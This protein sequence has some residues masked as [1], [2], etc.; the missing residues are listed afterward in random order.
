MFFIGGL[1]VTRSVEKKGIYLFIKD[2]FLRLFLPFI[3]GGTLFMLLAYFPAFYLAHHS[4]D[5]LF[6]IKDFFTTESWPVGPPWFIWV[7]F[8]FNMLFVIIY[9][10]VKKTVRVKPLKIVDLQNNPA[11]VLIILFA[12]TWILYVPVALQTGPE[13]WTGFGPFDFQVSRVLLYFGYFL[14]GA[15]IGVIDFNET[16]FSLN[17]PFVKKWRLWAGLSLL[18]FILLRLVTPVLVKAVDENK[19]S[20]LTS[21]LIYYSIYVLTG[22][23]TC[24]AFV[25][26]IRKLTGNGFKYWSSLSQ[27]AYLIYLVHFVFVTWMQFLLLGW[28]LPATMKFGLTFIAAL[29]LSWISAIQLRKIKVINRFL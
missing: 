15:L 10:L 13:K 1:F 12:V 8:A 28:Q 20:A 2:R 21:L 19:I 17:A 5:V 3:I 11:R 4:T 26:V 16:L 7:L 18:I 25:T 6:Y 14:T 9:A 27:N 23:L 22:T 24:I 29:A